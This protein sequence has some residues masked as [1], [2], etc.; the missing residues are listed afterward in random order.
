[1]AT[2]KELKAHE[3]RERNLRRSLENAERYVERDA[4]E[5]EKTKAYRDNC[6]KALDEHLAKTPELTPKQAAARS[7]RGETIRG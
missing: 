4:K 5:L 7:K 3:E 6:R 2:V 1:M